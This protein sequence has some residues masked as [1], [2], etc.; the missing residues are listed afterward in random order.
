MAS[1][2]RGVSPFIRLPL[3]RPRPN[4]L[5]C[6]CLRSFTTSSVQLSG[7]NKW[8]KIKHEKGAA[9]K[10]R[11]Q[12]HGSIAKLLTLYSKRPSILPASHVASKE[13]RDSFMQS[14]T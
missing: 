13:T 8:S 4:S 10:K 12:L 3:P 14:A 1:V 6:Q 11:S 2:I 7:H 5:Q 9:D